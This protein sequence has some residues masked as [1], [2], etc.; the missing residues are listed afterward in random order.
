MERQHEIRM[1][2]MSHLSDA[3]HLME[4]GLKEEANHCINFAK[5]LLLEYDDVNEYITENK[6]ANLW[7]QI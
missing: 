7:E 4:I 6:L 5:L 1:T 3:Q 2:I